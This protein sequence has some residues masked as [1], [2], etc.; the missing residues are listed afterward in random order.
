[1]DGKGRPPSPNGAILMKV[2]E[3]KALRAGKIDAMETLNLEMS[4][5]DYEE[6]E[7]KTQAYDELK[8]EVTGLD[9]KIKQTEEVEKL[10]ATLAKPVE[11]Q[12]SRN[13]DA[14]DP[15]A[16]PEALHQA[17][18]LQGRAAPRSAP[19]ASGNGSGARS[20]ATRRPASGAA[21]TASPSP[22]PSP[23]AS[24]R[25]AGFLVPT[26][27]MDSI[28]DLREEFGVFRQNAQL[29]PMSSDTLDWPRRSG[30]LTA[31][32]TAE[33]TAATESRRHLGQ[34]QPRR[35]ENRRADPH[36]E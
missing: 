8:G 30:G 15:G 26:E 23:K 10:K 34:R 20:S 31:Y 32:F 18:G 17:E 24:I 1:M 19:T 7:V 33:N 25:P 13:R 27:M 28:I 21:T 36:L 35:Q 14:A 2:N 6:D 16:G 22:A 11:G 3:L 12:R 5:E 29:V 9:K 4:A